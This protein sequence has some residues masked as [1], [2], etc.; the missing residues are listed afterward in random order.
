[1]V[2]VDD[3]RIVVRPVEQRSDVGLIVTE[4]HAV[5]IARV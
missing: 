5:E 2:A 3:C 4:H 1:M